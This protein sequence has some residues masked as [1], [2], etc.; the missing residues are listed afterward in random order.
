MSS[1]PL[2]RFKAVYHE[3]FMQKKWHES[4]DPFRFAGLTVLA[5]PGEPAEVAAAIRST[6]DSLRKQQGLSGFDEPI[7]I[8]VS[9]LL[10]QR[11][12]SVTDFL[13]AS[14]QIRKM[15]RAEKVRRGSIYEK[16]AFLIMFLQAPGGVVTTEHVLR[17][18]AIYEQM[19]KYHWWLT[20]PDDFPVCA[21]LVF[22]EGSPVQIGETIESIY[23]ALNEKGFSKGDPLQTAANMLYLAGQSPP[24]LAEKYRFIYELFRKNRVRIYQSDYDELA[25]LS[26][27]PQDPRLIVDRMLRVRTELAKLKPKPSR[28]VN[29]DL[30]VGV[31][32]VELIQQDSQR[33]LVAGAQALMNMQAI[34]AAQQAAVAAAVAASV[35]ATTAAAASS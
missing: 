19:K 29:F 32:F 12:R 13:R 17:F 31:T 26:M 3:L 6:A 1:E 8:L 27:L 10:V 9:A 22:Q 25:I 16:L 34:I 7:R 24:L 14:E 5:C 21:I 15:F 20:G 35:A 23:Q 18:K 11:Q 28:E 2:E 33:D 4:S 30:A